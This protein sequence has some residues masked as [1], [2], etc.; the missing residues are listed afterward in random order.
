MAKLTSLPPWLQPR[1]GRWMYGQKLSTTQEFWSGCRAIE[2]VASL[3]AEC[4]AGP[5][6]T[7]RSVEPKV[8]RHN[9]VPQVQCWRWPNGS[10]RAEGIDK[11]DRDFN[12]TVEL[13]S[14]QEAPHW[15][16][17]LWR[18]NQQTSPSTRKEALFQTFPVCE[19][20]LTKASSM[21]LRSAGRG[22]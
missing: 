13:L 1:C 5:G 4:G 2:E 19:Q 22:A 14:T 21:Y 20:A 7:R 6:S 16:V 12:R 17:W 10:Q 3:P 8:P 11:P 9:G 18:L 15:P